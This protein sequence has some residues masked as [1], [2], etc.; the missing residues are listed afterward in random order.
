MGRRKTDEGLRS[1]PRANRRLGSRY[2]RFSAV[3]CWRRRTATGRFPPV[4]TGSCRPV[5]AIRHRYSDCG[6][7]LRNFSLMCRRAQ[8]R[9][10]ANEP[11]SPNERSPCNAEK[12]CSAGGP[13]IGNP[14]CKQY[15]ARRPIDR[16]LSLVCCIGSKVPA[17]ERFARSRI[18]KVQA[19]P[20]RQYPSNSR[21]AAGISGGH[22]FE[23]RRR[24]GK[25]WSFE[26]G[27]R[28]L[29]RHIRQGKC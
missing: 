8:P 6:K 9:R 19:P 21:R 16:K 18:G 26:G 11:C 15:H 29:R 4:S 12:Y 20:H 3:N 7:L 27:P 10:S 14:K 5:P 25:D 1:E 13:C 24:I 17:K 28:S 2:D 22:L 23:A